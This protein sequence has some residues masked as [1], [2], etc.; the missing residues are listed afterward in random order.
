MSTHDPEHEPAGAEHSAGAGGGGHG[1]RGYAGHGGGGAHEE[2]EGA[3][4][5]LISFADNVT[6]MMGFFVIMLALAMK[7]QA[8]G[9]ANAGDSDQGS[10]AGAPVE[11]LEWALGVREAFN[12]PVL[13]E[14]SNPRDALL[15]AYLRQKLAGE[16]DARGVGAKGREHDVQS[17]RPSSY[18][19]DGVAVRFTSGSD[20]LDAAASADVDR[21]ARRFAG[22]K[23]MVEIR[24]H[25]S[26]AESH[27]LPD[28]GMSLAYARALAAARRLADAGV[29]WRRLRL[30]ACAD[31]D[32][33][34]DEGYDTATQQ[35]NQ[36]VEVFEVRP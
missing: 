1:G 25:C 14:S 10:F 8:G 27:D 7:P 15:A 21:I 9:A 19:S 17:I 29:D 11:E 4:E 31:G 13:P 34:D 20:E 23:A 28:R 22:A 24:G 35:A 26:A 2:H 18:Y 6:L 33:I 30:T 12:N 3:P 16:S 36:R 5:W 32:R